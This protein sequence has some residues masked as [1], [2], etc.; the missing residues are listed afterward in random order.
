MAPN[1]TDRQQAFIDVWK[2]IEA[3]K[4]S[5]PTYAEISE[6]FGFASNNSVRQILLALEKKGVFTKIGD[7]WEIT[8]VGKFA[9]L[10]I[11]T[12]S[13][14]VDASPS[15]GTTG[16]LVGAGMFPLRE[17]M[18]IVMDTNIYGSPVYA[19]VPVPLS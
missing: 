10:D 15:S 2:E 18:R 14:L 11:N 16:S 7:S 1:L 8:H 6:H 19:I 4:G 12:R 9:V 3:K 5:N 13:Y 17:A